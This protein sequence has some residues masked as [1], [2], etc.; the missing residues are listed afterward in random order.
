MKGT[1]DDDAPPTGS[2]LSYR[3]T[4][5]LRVEGGEAEPERDD[6]AVVDATERARKARSE[7]G[8]KSEAVE[9]V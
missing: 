8:A 4:E 6:P 1:E 7:P 3:S 9:V 5:L 2:S